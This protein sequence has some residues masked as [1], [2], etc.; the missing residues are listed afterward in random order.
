MF[1]CGMGLTPSSGIYDVEDI[2]ISPRWLDMGGW[3]VCV[4]I[5]LTLGGIERLIESLGCDNII[6]IRNWVLKHH[7]CLLAA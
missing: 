7:F 6:D 4:Y 2:R 5:P 3:V 1:I